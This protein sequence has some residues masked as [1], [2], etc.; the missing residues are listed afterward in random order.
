MTSTIDFFCV[1]EATQKQA[2]LQREHNEDLE[3][4]RREQVK[5]ITN[6]KEANSHHKNAWVMKK[7]ELEREFREAKFISDSHSQSYEAEC[8]SLANQILTLGTEKEHILGCLL[9]QKIQHSALTGYRESYCWPQRPKVAELP[10]TL[11]SRM[12]LKRQPQNRC[13][14]EQP[15]TICVED[16]VASL[17]ARALL[18]K[19]DLEKAKDGARIS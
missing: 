14:Q 3:K 19:V 18:A 10:S 5:I 9:K 11:A 1:L 7:M 6:V 17:R 2:V 16:Y 8:S 15:V 12:L 4:Q 13:Q